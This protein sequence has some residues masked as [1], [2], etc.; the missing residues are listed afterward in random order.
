M[1]MRLEQ[2]RQLSQSHRKYKKQSLDR[3]THCKANRTKPTQHDEGD[4]YR[5]TVSSFEPASAASRVWKRLLW[6]FLPKTAFTS[7]TEREQV[8]E[9]ADQLLR[10]HPMLS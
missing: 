1:T 5:T 2:T 9:L 4:V 3:V 8:V 7:E 6:R 10:H